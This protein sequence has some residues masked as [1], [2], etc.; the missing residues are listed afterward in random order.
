MAVK[1]CSL[2]E[3]QV[4]PV[5][6]KFSWPIFLLFLGIPYLIYRAIFVRK[7]RCPICGTK[8]LIS[9]DKAAKQKE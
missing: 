6:K 2:C 5:K 7:N 9:V 3:R 1:Y 4:E 8:R